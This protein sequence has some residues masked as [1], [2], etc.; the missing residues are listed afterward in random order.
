[1]R[2]N[3]TRRTDHKRPARD[4]QLVHDLV[5]T[6]DSRVWVR[7]YTG[8]ER[9]YPASWAVAVNDP[10]QEAVCYVNSPPVFRVEDC[11]VLV[12]AFCEVEP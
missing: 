2:A 6:S 8:T 1:M 9:T 3:R 4:R 10:V 5:A 12:R 7:F 11:R